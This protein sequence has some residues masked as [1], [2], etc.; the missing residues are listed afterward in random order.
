MPKAGRKIKAKLKEQYGS[1]KGE[2]IFYAM[3]NKGEIPGMNKMKG[4]Q[5]GGQV[6]NQQQVAQARQVGMAQS[7]QNAA[8]NQRNMAMAQKRNTSAGNRMATSPGQMQAAQAQQASMA[9]SRRVAANQQK[10]ADTATNQRNMVMAQSR[11]AS[12]IAQPNPFSRRGMAKGGMV[13][14]T[15]KMNT[16]IKKCGE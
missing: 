9:Q 2:E 3:E 14:S 12:P 8:T 13:K 6:P 11:R 15:G 16:G 4:Y 7:K 10:P 1:E 5:V